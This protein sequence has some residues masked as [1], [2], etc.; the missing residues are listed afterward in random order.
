MKVDAQGNLY[1]A[2]PGGL[3]VFGPDGEALGRVRVPEQ[4]ANFTWG[5]ADGRSLFITASSSLYRLRVRAPGR[6]LF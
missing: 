5:E 3:H 1:C 2:G 6:P 4:A